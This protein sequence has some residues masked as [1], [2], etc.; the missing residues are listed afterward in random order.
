VIRINL[1]PP[2][3]VQKRKDEKRWQ[4]VGLGTVVLAVVIALV[5]SVL[6]FQVVGKQADVAS[7][8]QEA[9]DL[10]SETSRFQIFQQQ[11]A[12]LQ[13]REA[14][15]AAASQGRVDWARMF[16]ELGLVLPSDSYLTAF[17]GSEGSAGAEGVV[18]L[19]GVANDHPDN[20]A[21]SGYKTVA[22]AL[23]RL[24]DLQQLDS[25][26]L[27]NAALQ[28]SATSTNTAPPINFDLTAKIASGAALKPVTVTPSG[29]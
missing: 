24:A 1:I 9:A 25:V 19:S 22:K 28:V 2:E 16:N 27:T 29:N 14:A 23:V 4:W 8:K 5:Y 6:L 15:V 20:N 3:I 17:N 18:T 12:D 7:V 11:Q 21:K 10:Q 13:L 26:W